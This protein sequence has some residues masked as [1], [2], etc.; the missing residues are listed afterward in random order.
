MNQPYPASINNGGDGISALLDAVK[1]ILGYEVDCWAV[2]DIQAAA[3][4]VDA[5]GGVYYDIPYDMD[6]DAPDQNPPVSIH[7]KQGYQLL[8]L[9]LI[10]I[11]RRSSRSRASAPGPIRP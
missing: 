7:I 2:I 11:C 1:D 3:D 4:I 8:D 5:I 10:H 6:W 9:S